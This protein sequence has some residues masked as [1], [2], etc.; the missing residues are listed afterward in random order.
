[1]PKK[2]EAE[3]P[4][5]AIEQDFLDAIARIQEGKPRNRELK[6][7]AARGKLALNPLTVSLEAGHSRTLIGKANGCRYPRVRKIIENTKVAKNATPTTYTELVDRLRAE[8]AELS[9][10]LNLY[11]SE[12]L[13]HFTA[14]AKAEK[15]AAVAKET[16]AKLVKEL[17]E[18]G[19]VASIVPKGNR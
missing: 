16:N 15:A 11:K 5:D 3:P 17:A 13:E 14:R 4:V 10:Q 2:R 6:A 19:K 7:R 12:A 18:L 8:K 9:H 1:M